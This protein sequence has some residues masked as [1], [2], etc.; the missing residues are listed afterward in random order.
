[1]SIDEPHGC[2]TAKERDAGGAL[3]IVVVW[4]TVTLLLFKFVEWL[5]G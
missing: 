5:C 3:I 4:A 2:R 1:M